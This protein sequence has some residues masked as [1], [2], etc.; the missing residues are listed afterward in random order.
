VPKEPDPLIAAQRTYYDERAPDYMDL[1]KPSDRKV[2]GWM[3]DEVSAAL[4]DEFAPTGNVLELACGHGVSTRHI[5]RHAATVTALDGSA[6]MIERNREIVK[7]PKVR[8]VEADVFAWEPDQTYDA[9]FFSYWLS[10]VPPS[11]FDDFWRLVRACLGPGGRVGFIDEDNRAA[12]K[13]DLSVIDGVPVA[14][15]TLSDG[16]EFDIVKAL[17]EPGDL[18]S[19]LRS[20]GW[21]IAVR[22]VGD[23]FFFGSGS[24][25]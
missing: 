10:H 7:S 13:E 5:V 15:R 6:R 16:R 17:W 23:S 22:A 14:R 1:S 12:S 8:Y 19:R 18:E 2:R 25:F 9:V 4:I 21:D 3:S 20:S 24:S 11:R